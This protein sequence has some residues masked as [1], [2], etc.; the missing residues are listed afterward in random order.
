MIVVV[1]RQQCENNSSAEIKN[2][3]YDIF[4]KA[5]LIQ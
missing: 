5:A 2:E 4:V 1:A 3:L